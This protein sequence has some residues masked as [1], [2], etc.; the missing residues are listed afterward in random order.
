MYVKA[1]IV[2][3]AVRHEQTGGSCCHSFVH[4]TLHKAEVLEALKHETNDCKMD[5]LIADARPCQP[6]REVVAFRNYRVYFFLLL[7]E[8]AAA[9]QSAGEIRAVVAGY[10][11]AGVDDGQTAFGDYLVMRMVVQCLTVL[12]QDG[13][14]GRHVASADYHAFHHTHEVLLQ[15]A[16]LHDLRGSHVH[17]VAEVAGYVNLLY[18]ARFLD[19][20]HLHY[21]F[22]EFLARAVLHLVERNAQK[23]VEDNHVAV[24]VLRQEMH[25][26]AFGHGFLQNLLKLCHRGCLS[27]T[28]LFGT[29]GHQGLRSHPDDVVEVY[30]VAEDNL[31]SALHID[32][33]RHVWLIYTEIVKP[34]AVLTEGVLVVTVV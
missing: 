17:G 24:A 14:E 18:L 7:G 34:G 19:E 21:G 8:A 23:F 20:A 6:Q 30:I 9:G 12:R 13:G 3:K 32:D 22:D 15:Q 5:V 25:L 27:H 28:Y 33:G 4:I 11:R 29:A 2:A 31:F 1:H 10:L 16:G 26:A